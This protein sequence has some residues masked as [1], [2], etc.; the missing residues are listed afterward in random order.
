MTLG[1]H[2][3]IPL[4]SRTSCRCNPAMDYARVSTHS[5]RIPSEL[6]IGGRNVGCHHHHPSVNLSPHQS[7]EYERCQMQPVIPALAPVFLLPGAAAFARCRE[8]NVWCVA[9]K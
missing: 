6:A 7:E 1:C 3:T 4:I 2:R 5:F 8:E 9:E